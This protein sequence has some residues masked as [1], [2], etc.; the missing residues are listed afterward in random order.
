MQVLNEQERDIRMAINDE[1]IAADSTHGKQLE[2]L[3]D[4]MIKSQRQRIDLMEAEQK[5]LATVLSPLQRASY[6][7]IQEQMRRAVEDMRRGGGP[8][9]PGGPGGRMGP[10]DGQPQGPPPD[11]M[12][13]NGLRGR[14]IR[15]PPEEFDPQ[16]RPLPQRPVG[17][18][19]VPPY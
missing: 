7:G 4:R 6:L 18:G 14:G 11:G 16:G 2:D 15:R 10:P 5:D 8:G 3:L 9:G 13:P 1:R 19:V 17:R 12:G